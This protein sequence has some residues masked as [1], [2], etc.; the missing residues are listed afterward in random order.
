VAYV[1]NHKFMGFYNGVETELET[2]VPTKY[3]MSPN[4]IAY[5][6]VS[7]RLKFFWK[8]K[9]Y[10]ASYDLITDFTLNGD[11]L[12]YET[13]PLHTQFFFDGKGY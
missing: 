7:G 12:S 3:E 10:T 11:V 6:D 4:G 2:Y 9:L 5:L 8:G 13:G 1:M